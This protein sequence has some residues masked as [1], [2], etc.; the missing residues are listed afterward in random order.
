MTFSSSTTLKFNLTVQI[1]DR[2]FYDCDFEQSIDDR[3]Y[4]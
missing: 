2:L 4:G 3:P 1:I